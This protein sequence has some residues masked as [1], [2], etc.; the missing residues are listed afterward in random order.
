MNYEKFRAVARQTKVQFPN[1]K[2][3][4]KWGSEKEERSSIKTFTKK[5][6]ERD[7]K[8]VKQIVYWGVY[9]RLNDVNS[10]GRKRTTNDLVQNGEHVLYVCVCVRT[11]CL[12][13]GINGSISELYAL[14]L[15]DSQEARYVLFR[16]FAINRTEGKRST[17][18]SLSSHASC[19]Q[20]F[21]SFAIQT[22]PK[23]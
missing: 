5:A 23:K 19:S 2:T 16:L 10:G 13:H 12:P 4:V 17:K 8:A 15:V 9:A 6:Q 22:L 7:K 20:A 18:N 3:E 1:W 11:K 21:S 14:R